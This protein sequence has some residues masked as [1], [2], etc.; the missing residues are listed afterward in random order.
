MAVFQ[1][2]IEAPPHTLEYL[3]D[4]LREEANAF[5]AEIHRENGEFQFD[6]TPG[7][8][9]ASSS[10]GG[11][12]WTLLGLPKIEPKPEADA[13]FRKVGVVRVSDA[14]AT[15]HARRLADVRHATRLVWR[16]LM[17][18]AFDRAVAAGQ[19]RLYARIPSPLDDFQ[20]LP[21]DLWP[22]LEVLDWEHGVAVDLDGT[23]YR[24]IHAVDS[25]LPSATVQVERSSPIANG[26]VSAMP[27][28]SGGQSF[29]A[30]DAVLVEE[31][32]L[33]ITKGEVSSVTAAARAVTSKAQKLGSEESVVERL[34]RAYGRQYPTR[35]NV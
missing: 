35:R 26:G 13:L 20:G 33:L 8:G 22:Q 27:D 21:A 9:G 31:M 11:A 34:R 6:F 12:P 32:R 17:L 4:L 28:K 2:G 1:F 5:K 15:E 16:G 25:A 3:A 23:L 18:P 24:S 30:Q 29:K 7:G 19:V 10:W 14:E